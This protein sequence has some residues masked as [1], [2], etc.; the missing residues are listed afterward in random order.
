MFPFY[1]S[2]ITR[3]PKLS[4]FF[5]GYRKGAMA[6]NELKP[7]LLLKINPKRFRFSKKT[8]YLLLLEI[9]QTAAPEHVPKQGS[10]QKTALVK[11][12]F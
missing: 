3:K 7:K 12:C 2:K 5:R 9:A 10:R 8:T 6:R 4:D 1:T 11:R